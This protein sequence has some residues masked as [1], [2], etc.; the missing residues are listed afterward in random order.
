MNTNDELISTF[1][2]LN[3]RQRLS[4]K[5]MVP[6]EEYLITGAE[7][8]TTKYGETVV[9]E[10]G[11]SILYLPRRFNSLTDKEIEQLSK[12][13]YLILKFPLRDD[14]DGYLYRLELKPLPPMREYYPFNTFK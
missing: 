1:N 4:V 13:S 2:K 10:L 8:I 6:L 12:G 11:T 14:N 9:I 5:D 3:A 7:R